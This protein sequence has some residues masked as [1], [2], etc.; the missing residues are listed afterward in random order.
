MGCAGLSPGAARVACR[1][2]KTTLRWLGHAVSVLVDGR[3][4][5]SSP[6]ESHG[7]HKVA[8][9]TTR[10]AISASRII[11]YNPVKSGYSLIVILIVE[12]IAW[13]AN[14]SDFQHCKSAMLTKLGLYGDGSGLMLQITPT[15]AKS[16]L[17]RYMVAGKPHGMGLGSTHTVSLA[18]ARQKALG[19]RKLLIDGINPLVAKKQN[20]IA[21]ALADTKMMTFDQCAE[22]Y[23]LAHKAGWRNAKHGDQWTNTLNAYAS[24]VFGHLP[25][26]DVDTG[27][28]VK[29]LAPIW[30]SKTETASRVRGRIE[31]VC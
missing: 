19:A 22:A 24:P 3:P 6:E 28:V 26:A 31:S 20:Q 17:L 27:L 11:L 15:G 7:V 2:K 9:I 4:P 25:V 8:Y 21:A 18:E 1:R 5:D 23:I 12:R 30:E 29:C 10:Y 16:W 13:H 14:N